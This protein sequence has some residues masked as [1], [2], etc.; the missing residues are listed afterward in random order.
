MI[1]LDVSS[2]KV[3][4]SIPQQ[5]FIAII[6][7]LTLSFMFLGAVAFAA[8]DTG[9]FDLPATDITILNPDSKEV[10]GHAHY[11]ITHQDGV[12][13]FEGENRFLDGEYD[14]EVERV[15]PRG[16]GTAPVLLSY[17][18]SFFYADGSPE[19]I[20]ALNA[21]TGLLACTHFPNGTPDVRTSKVVV[22]PDT[23]AGSTQLMLLVGRL[24]EG[25]SNIK[26][27]TFICLGGP[28]IVPMK[29]TPPASDAKWPMYPGNLVKVE[30]VPD[31]GWLG[32]LAGPLIPKAYRWF[33]PADHFNYV[34]GLFDRFYRHH[35]LLMVCTP[36]A[37][38]IAKS[39]P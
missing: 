15:E 35:N 38:T 30:M 24:R 37:G 26:M 34:G 33:D 13:L 6:L 11:K 27:H 32:A 2:R 31:F 19:S 28:H 20:D 23:Y 14:Q 7:L 1:Q 18:H 5:R 3:A 16:D 10:L 22:P 12:I 9:I 21:T 36:P 39:K 17:Q 25:E 29:V 4:T 8:D